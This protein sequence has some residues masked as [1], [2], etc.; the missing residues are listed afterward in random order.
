MSE[1]T[2]ETVPSG[3]GYATVVLTARLG[4]VRARV[5]D[6]AEGGIC[7]TDVVAGAPWPAD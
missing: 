3:P 2:P 1:A 7:L 6:V 4:P 5:T